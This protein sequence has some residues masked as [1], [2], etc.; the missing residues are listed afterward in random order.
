MTR[1]T[2]WLRECII[3]FTEAGDSR[4]SAQND[5]I[6]PL[7]LQLLLFVVEEAD[8]SL[9]DACDLLCTDG[10]G[11][12]DMVEPQLGSSNYW[13]SDRKILRVPSAP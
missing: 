12:E 10:L 3:A 5:R 4:G 11:I 13:N 1:N 2:L 9:E 8:G 6:C 7:L